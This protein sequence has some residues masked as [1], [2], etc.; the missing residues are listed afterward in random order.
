EDLRQRRGEDDVPEDLPAAGAQRARRLD[1]L[2]RDA[3]DAVHGGDRRDRQRGQEEEDDLGAIPDPE[4]D[5]QQHQVGELGQRPEELDQ[6]VEEG[7]DLPVVAHR[8]PEQ[9]PHRRPGGEAEEHALEAERAVLP[10]RAA[11][12]AVLDQVDEAVP[13]EAGPRQEEVVHP[14][15]ARDR[16]P[17]GPEQREHPDGDP[18]VSE[19]TPPARPPGRAHSTPRQWTRPASSARISR[20]SAMPRR[21]RT[22]MPR[23]ITSFRRNRLAEK[24][25]QPRPSVAAI[26]SAA[27]TVENAAA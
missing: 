3:L 10:Q 19:A 18:P 2:D 7:L 1:P 12:V 22:R 20:L 14:P 21:P 5:D 13:Q 17:R 26:S 16:D 4:P 6:R 9:R 8:Q 23:M 11:L 25:I 24:T 27:T 15:R